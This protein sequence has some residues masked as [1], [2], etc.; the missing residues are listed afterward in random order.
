MFYHPF[1]QMLYL[2]LNA[3]LRPNT[4]YLLLVGLIT[5]TFTFGTPLFGST[6]EITH[7]AQNTTY[8]TLAAVANSVSAAHLDLQPSKLHSI[9]TA[10]PSNTVHNATPTENEEKV[11]TSN[12]IP[13]EALTDTPETSAP[14]V[15]SSRPPTVTSKQPQD[16]AEPTVEHSTPVKQPAVVDIPV[17]DP[18]VAPPTAHSPTVDAAAF[19]TLH[20]EVRRDLDLPDLTWSASLAA[21]AQ[22]WADALADEQCTMRHSDEPYGENIFTLWTNNPDVEANADDAVMWWAGEADYYDYNTNTCEPGEQCGHYT[23]MIWN[24]TTNV[25]CARSQCTAGSKTTHLFVCRYDPQ[26]NIIG[27]K[28]Y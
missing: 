28:P 8:A 13:K 1:T 2:V 9:A 15:A 7:R 24:K 12:S 27:Q 5:I 18:V 26:G 19:L 16:A 3:M 11:V 14:H 20:N 23:Q 17:S 10:T 6:S 25:G 21:G 22:T 4:Q